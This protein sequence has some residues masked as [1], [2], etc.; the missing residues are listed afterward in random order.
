MT[1][2]IFAMFLA[3][4]MV[5]SL[6]PTSVFAAG[7]PAV[8]TKDN[9]EYTQ[10]G[11]PVA[12]TCGEQGYT[13]Y[14]CNACGKE[15]IADQVPAVGEHTWVDAE[16]VPETCEQ[17]G[18]TGGKTCSVC[19]KTVDQTKVDKIPNDANVKCV[20]EDLTPNIDC[21]T[22]GTKQYQCKVCGATKKGEEIKE[23]TP[24][25]WSDWT[26]KT[27]AT[28]EVPGLAERKC[29]ACN[30]VEECVVFAAHD[31]V[32]VDVAEVAP[33]CDEPG[34]AAHKVCRICN[35]KF[36]PK[37]AEDATL[38]EKTDADLRI[39]TLHEQI[40]DTLTCMT[41][42]YPCDECDEVIKVNKAA[43]HKYT[44]GWQNVEEAT[45]TTDGFEK[46]ICTVC[47]NTETRIIDALGH[48]ERNW[49]VDATC[50]QYG[51]TFTYCLRAGCVEVKTATTVKVGNTEV[52]FDLTEGYSDLETPIV[53]AGFY[54]NVYQGTLEKTFYF[55]GRTALEA[56]TGRYDRFMNTV[57]EITDG[58]LVYLEEVEV[59]GVENAY[60]MYFFK[61]E[62]SVKTYL[63]IYQNGS[64]VNA[65]MG[66][67]VPT[68]YWT[69]NTTYKTLTTKVGEKEYYLGAYDNYNT[70]GCS[71]LSYLENETNYSAKMTVSNANGVALL[72]IEVNAEAGFDAENH[73]D[74]KKVTT[75]KPTCKEG[76][77]NT[78]LCYACSVSWTEEEA[79]VDHKWVADTSKDCDADC[80]LT[81]VHVKDGVQKANCTDKGAKY[82]VCGFDCGATKVEEEAAKGHSAI[83]EEKDGVKVDVV[84]TVEGG[85]MNVTVYDYKVC[86][87]CGV[88][89]EKTN[90]RVWE[91]V[92]KLWT[93]LACE[94]GECG[95]CATCAHDGK[96]AE[97][98]EVE[99]EGDCSK[100]GYKGYKCSE[101]GEVVR[102]KT[103]T[104]GA[105][106]YS[107]NQHKDPTCT[108]PGWDI[109]ERC[110]RCDQL[111]DKTQEEGKRTELP[112]IEHDW[113][114]PTK[115]ERKELD[116][117]AE[118]YEAAP[119]DKPN[120]ENWV[121]YCKD[122]GE[123]KNDGTKLLNTITESTAASLCGPVV[124]EWYTCHCGE[125]HIRNYVGKIAHVYIDAV[126]GDVEGDLK[127]DA[128]CTAPGFIW[129]KCQ[130]CGE[131]KKFDIAQKAHQNK[132]KVEF[133]DSCIDTVADRHCV[134]CCACADKK[135]HDCTAD[136]D[137][138][139]KGVQTCAC[140]IPAAEHNWDR[141]DTFVPAHCAALPYSMR[142]CVD[143]GKVEVTNYPGYWDG[144]TKDA[145]GNPV[146]KPIVGLNHT[147]VAYEAGADKAA[148]LKYVETDVYSY[149]LADDGMLR[150][151][152]ETITGIYTAYTAATFSAAGSATF[153]CSQCNEE[154]TIELPAL[155]GLGFELVAENANGQDGLTMGSL[156]NVTLYVSGS[157]VAVNH[158]ELTAQFGTGMIFVGAQSAND[159]FG[160]FVTEAAN[161]KGTLEIIANAVNTAD[162]KQQNI[163][164][165]DKTPIATM[166]FIV[167]TEEAVNVNMTGSAQDLA[168]NDIKCA[169][170]K[171]CKIEVRKFMDFNDDGFT[172]I[173]DLVQAEA[174]LTGE[175][176][177][178]YDVTVDADKD[179]EITLYDLTLIYEYNVNKMDADALNALIFVGMAE[180]HVAIVRE[181]LG[182]NAH[183]Y[184]CNNPY[185]SF[186]D[187]E[188]IVVCPACYKAQ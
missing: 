158:F 185:C 72:D 120:Y 143:C 53:G 15:F 161:A 154:V 4:L 33:K 31:H 86:Y 52:E 142:V 145:K 148:N 162:K 44:N 146:L 62:E 24:H 78:W 133:V 38:V 102:V 137:K 117:W 49:T 16:D 26:L 60:H 8:H 129:K 171:E 83:Y 160:I 69:W 147:P 167:W 55:D 39:K 176:E 98:A 67:T 150:Q 37:S 87:Y 14:K 168:E 138:D 118:E 112:V 111:K 27:A 178:T 91:G 103:A 74:K 18:W 177:K 166:Q 35:V 61:G 45:C 13:R 179:G 188:P 113:Y 40:Q 128:T 114:T 73:A 127:L 182:L 134:L 28:A 140:V 41:T 136:Q 64:Y 153:V 104:T 172:L 9:C 94:D 43:A 170:A 110:Q 32:L 135:D 23:N 96:L 109:N 123:K 116:G 6:L 34:V 22:G 1:K 97:E 159:D 56:G 57:E 47:G 132:D 165:G 183:K 106:K 164:I 141:E 174:I 108:E 130:F 169:A 157:N 70:L 51:Y 76:V 181:A 10:V 85:H 48:I 180:E 7:C 186:T 175:S 5:V 75:L 88:E 100:V 99:V 65:G 139:T 20:W 149:Y 66:T 125:N 3:L 80:A 12:P 25:T 81:H 42:T 50:A 58:V 59:E 155:S 124:Y 184:V 152:V 115:E 105:H 11:E 90:F 79:A 95:E 77:T 126:E 131:T 2:K 92:G 121:A 21:T 17:D 89:L 119:C 29:S 173:S 68:T 122:C 93:V 82:F 187:D 36:G 84:Y 19:K 107:E 144:E 30:K 151:K 54:L 101:C 156:V 46:R 63:Y 163:T 71:E